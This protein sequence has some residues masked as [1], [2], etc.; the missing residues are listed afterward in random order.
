MLCPYEESVRRILRGE[1]RI[2]IV[3]EMGHLFGTKVAKAD[4]D[5]AA[6]GGCGGDFPGVAE[7][8]EAG[9]ENIGGGTYAR[10]PRVVDQQ[11]RESGADFS[12]CDEGAAEH[13]CEK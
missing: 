3:L 11:Q 12:V 2:F 9:G 1:R 8:Q 6:A 7:R 5:L 10:E 13:V 4:R